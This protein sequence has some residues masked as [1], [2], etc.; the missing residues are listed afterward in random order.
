MRP[1]AR[2]HSF[3]WKQRVTT[4]LLVSVI[5][6]PSACGRAFLG[7]EQ[8]ANEVSALSQLK[9][10]STAQ[11]LV[12]VE[13]GRY[14]HSL[15]ELYEY[16]GREGILDEALLKAWDRARDPVPLNGYLFTEVEQEESGARLTDPWRCGLSAFPAVPGRSGD[17]VMLVLMDDGSGPSDLSPISDGGW[18]LYRAR[19][20]DLTGPVRRW[21]S[22]DELQTKFE[23][24][25]IRIRR[26]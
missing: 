7:A 1:H 19:V 16:A 5:L 23:Q 21:P 10:Y 25:T 6:A 26:P 15:P 4:A 18:R 12:S 8:K 14:L 2:V 22:Q 17:H 9:K 24:K 11:A 20:E 13:T 3:S